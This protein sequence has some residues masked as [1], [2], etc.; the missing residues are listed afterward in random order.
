MNAAPASPRIPRIDPAA[1]RRH[2]ARAATREPAWLHGEI[3]RRMAGRLSLVRRAPATVLDWWSPTSASAEPLARHCPQAQVT[4]IGF[5][6]RPRPA[7]AGTSPWW[8]RLAGRAGASAPAVPATPPP[9][10]LLWANM[11]LHWVDDRPAM[12]ARWHAALQVDGFLMFSC[13]GPDTLRELRE[14]WAA[15]GWGEPCSAWTDMHDLGDDLV[16]AGFTDPVMDMERIALTWDSPAALLAE[17]RT[18]GLNTSPARH[19]G[20]RGRAWRAR[21]DTELTRRLAGPD[22]RLRLGFEIVYGHAFRTVTAP[23]VQ[24]Q[25]SISLD[26]MREMTRRRNPGRTE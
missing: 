16:H 13:F 7:P 25:T 9:A 20:W 4:P 22:G 8:R 11:M 18:L 17:L 24:P 14:V 10:D 6:D 19:P 3:A 1:L 23:R 5:D 15:L 21:L 26:E 2:L 12:L